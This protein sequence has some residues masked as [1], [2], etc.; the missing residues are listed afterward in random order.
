MAIYLAADHRG[1]K[2][3]EVIKKMLGECGVAFEDCGAQSLNPNDDYVDFAI[4]AA[5]KITQNPSGHKGVFLCGS[6]H[7]MDMVANKFK[8]IRAALCWNVHVAEQSREHDDANVLV[9]PA[10]WVDEETAQ[11]IIQTWL[12][13]RFS[14]E[15]RHTERLKKV[16]KLELEW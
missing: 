7:G 14:G 4:V 11:E 12:A 1:F 6:G 15:E 8:G 3:K 9:L 2:L 10:D 13:T 5:Q 16:Q